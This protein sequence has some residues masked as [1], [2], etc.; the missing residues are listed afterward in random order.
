MLECVVN[1]SEGRDAVR[2]EGF[3]RRAGPALLDLHADAS[4]NRS[5][6]TLA[7]PEV[8][9]AARD[10]AIAAVGGLEISS[11]E[12]VHPRLG[13]VD[14]VPFAPLG[15]GALQENGDLGEAIAARDRF[16]RWASDELAVPC[17]SYGPE[18]SLPEI[19]R[20]A[21]RDLPPDFG[22]A[23]PHP[24]AGA[25]CVGAR[26][27]L[28][29]Y[30]LW[31]AGGD[32]A[33]ARRIAAALR[34]HEVRAAAFAVGPGIQV[35]CNLVAPWSVGPADVYD[36]VAAHAGIERAELVGLIPEKVLRAVPSRRWTSLDLAEDSTI[37][38]R[39]ADRGI[40]PSG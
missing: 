1:I 5:V 6:F 36:R 26:L 17:F 4:H 29:A 23:A 7:G 38:A 8:F 11:H 22:P 13:V 21:F 12:G 28:V 10:L 27:A 40:V 25:C 18:R 16:C 14:V 31:L 39:L 33:L 35:S 9:D 19:R 3:A 20:R 2:L 24:S 34:S 15:D 32:L 37:E 30:N